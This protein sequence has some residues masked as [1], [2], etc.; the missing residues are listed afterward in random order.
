MAQILL[1][2]NFGESS[3]FESAE[4]S[5]SFDV[6]KNMYAQLAQNLIADPPLPYLIW[7]PCKI[8]RP[9][10]PMK[11]NDCGTKLQS[12]SFVCVNKRQIFPRFRFPKNKSPFQTKFPQM[13]IF[14]K[15]APTLWKV[16]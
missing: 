15:Y 9:F 7:N 11:A 6:N 2:Q 16:T 10:T 5:D 1:A 12:M 8:E 13:W 4:N 14:I 3:A